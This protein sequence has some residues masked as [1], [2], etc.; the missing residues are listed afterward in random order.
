MSLNDHP[1]RSI[2][3]KI[4]AIQ[5]AAER[6]AA[7]YR[8]KNAREQCYTTQD[9]QRIAHEHA[10]YRYVAMGTDYLTPEQQATIDTYQMVFK[11]VARRNGQ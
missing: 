7:P 10:D 8:D 6:D 4:Q 2:E 3:Y 9:I 11:N 5:D 1:P